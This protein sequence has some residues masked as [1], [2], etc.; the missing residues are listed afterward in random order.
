M[1]LC[2]MYQAEEIVRYV[3]LLSQV[4]LALLHDS[5]LLASYRHLSVSPFTAYIKGK[6]VVCCLYLWEAFNLIPRLCRRGGFGKA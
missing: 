3:P 6:Q 5:T 4:L 1:C 2:Y